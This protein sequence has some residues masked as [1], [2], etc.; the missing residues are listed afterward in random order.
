[1]REIKF[2]GKDIETGEWRYGSLIKTYDGR[3]F[4]QES[5][6]PLDTSTPNTVFEAYEV[7]PETVG[8]FTGLPDKNS[9][10]IYEGDVVEYEDYTH[11]AFVSFSGKDIQPRNREAVVTGNLFSGVH[12]HGSALAYSSASEISSKLEV[13]GNIHDNPTMII[14]ESEE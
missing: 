6:Q 10:E 4:I 1:M 5:G 9:V 3:R 14:P 8:E 13:I 12:L 11:G 2:R 7:D